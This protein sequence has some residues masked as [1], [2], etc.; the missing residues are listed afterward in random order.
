MDIQDNMFL[1][2]SNL[3]S[4]VIGNKI[5]NIRV[6]SFNGC[7]SLKDISLPNSLEI[8]QNSAF[9]NC[10]S[11]VNISLPTKLN[12]I[13]GSAFA[14]CSNLASMTIPP[15]VKEIG[16]TA[17]DNCGNLTRIII[18]DGPDTLNLGSDYI[19]YPGYTGCGLF[20]DCRLQAVYIGRNLSYNT[21]PR[22]GYS[23]FFSNATLKSVTISENVTMDIQ[24]NMFLNCAALEKITIGNKIK[25]IKSSAFNGCSS[26]TEVSLSDNL[27]TI[28]GSA[29]ANCGSL[30]N[31]LLPNKLVTIGGSCFANCSNLGFI[32]LP[33]SVKEIGNTAFDNCGSI[34][35][36]IIKDGPDT[37]NLGSDY[38]N[39]PGYTGCGLFQDCQL[40]AVY[41]GRNL[42]YNTEPRYG[43]SPFFNNATLNTVRFSE[44]V[45]MDIPDNMFL[46]C[47]ALETVRFSNQTQKINGSV[48]SGCSALTKVYLPNN[49]TYLGGSIFANCT[50]LTDISLPEKLEV[51]GGSAFANCSSLASITI[52]P[53]VKEIGNT[54]FDNCGSITKIIIKD[55]PDA[56]NLGS[57]YINYP[58]YTGCGLFQDCQL[59]AVYIG[60]NLSYNTESRYGYSPFFNNQ[61]LKS[62][63][64]CNRFQTIPNNLFKSCSNLKKLTVRRS[65]PPEIGGGAFDGVPKP[66]AT[67]YVPRNSVSSYQSA[68]GW[69]DFGTITYIR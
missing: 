39:Y 31:I 13:G 53:S 33:P 69:S 21:E 64:L 45:T 17:F 38:I 37:L 42:S 48:F 47:K 61:Y 22:Y 32:N 68:E 59:Q 62:A 15:S 30:T 43:Y 24:D 55:G 65:T 52:P 27:E 28:Y 11:L 8:I 12:T 16:N 60:R 41:I 19:N 20:Q 51:I 35:R 18:K 49:M 57:D 29:F 58:G 63:E 7:S 67:L 66:D 5:K 40:Q 4:V 1:N 14:N 3:K 54:A 50:S 56:L 44:T 9:A 25:T 36:I 23:P 6:S 26:L 34:I 2:C 46:N 10:K